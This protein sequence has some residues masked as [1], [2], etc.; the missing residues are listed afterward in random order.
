MGH[1]TEKRSRGRSAMGG[2]AE[3]K[4]LVDMWRSG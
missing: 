2:G 1:E 4:G 3:P